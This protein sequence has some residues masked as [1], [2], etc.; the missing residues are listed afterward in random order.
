ME[1]RKFSRKREAILGAL[2]ETKSHPTAEWVYAKLKPSYPDLSLGTVYRNLSLFLREGAVIKVASVNGQERY[3]ANTEPHPHF[4]CDG[5]GDVSDMDMSFGLS[6]PEE[7]RSFPG[8]SIDYC[9]V[10]YH[11]T[12]RK[13]SD[14]LNALKL[15][16]KEERK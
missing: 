2:R 7:R 12:C 15:F 11:G 9:D 16:F 6:L 3:D 1:I 8:G 5:C 4:I 10:V 13:C 14:K